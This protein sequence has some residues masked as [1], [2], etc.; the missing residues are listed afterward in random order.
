MVGQ[1]VHG[2]GRGRFHGNPGQ[3][4]LLPVPW[5]LSSSDE[6]GIERKISYE[7]HE[8]RRS[9]MKRKEEEEDRRL[10]SNN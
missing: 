8:N 10:F 9:T 6:G 5:H 1:R 7:S 4:T 3:A 2:A